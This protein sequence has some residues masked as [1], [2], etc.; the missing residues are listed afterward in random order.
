[1]TAL[2]GSLGFVPM[3]IATG[4]GA[5]K[6]PLAIA[7][8]R[9]GRIPPRMTKA[10]ADITNPNLAP[11]AIRETAGS[12]LA[13]W[14]ACAQRS[15]SRLRMPEVKAAT[16]SRHYRDI[17]NSQMTDLSL[18]RHLDATSTVH[19]S[20]DLVLA[21]AGDSNCCLNSLRDRRAGTRIVESDKTGHII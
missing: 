15:R 17:G 7:V 14:P 10:M 12:N 13:T 2:V 18:T 5:E 9:Q 4:A 19:C 6:R 8:I 20:G 11:I 21:T 3:A 1:M 16:L